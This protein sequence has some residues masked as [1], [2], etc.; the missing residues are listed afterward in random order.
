MLPSKVEI[1]LIKTGPE[2][3]TKLEIPRQQPKLDNEK[4]QYEDKISEEVNAV[5]L[6]DL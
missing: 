4:E 1:T 3:W 6:S 5:D 2:H